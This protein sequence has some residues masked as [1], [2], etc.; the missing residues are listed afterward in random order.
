MLSACLI[1]AAA[2][3]FNMFPPASMLKMIALVISPLVRF[4]TSKAYRWY[5]QVVGAHQHLG[6]P[7]RRERAFWV[8]TRG[9]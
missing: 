5:K 6:K 7:M 3:L 9:K 8:G 2:V 4:V 1:S